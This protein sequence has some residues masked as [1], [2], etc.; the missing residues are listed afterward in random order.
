L[1]GGPL[2]CLLLAIPAWAQ[3]APAPADSLSAREALAD[4]KAADWEALAK[5]LDT[6]IARMLPCD[7]RV[8]SA[9]EEVS[10]ASQARLAAIANYLNA[11][12]VETKSEAQRARAAIAQQDAAIQALGGE[13]AEVEQWRTALDAQMGD[14]KESAKRRQALEDALAKLGEIRG[15]MDARIARLAEE[16]SRRQGARASLDT[17]ASAYD[18][19]E[20]A[21]DAEV[22]A[23]A[24][25]SARWIEYYT[26]RLARAGTECSITQQTR[27]RRKRP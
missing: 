2:V 24:G 13:R 25:E 16:A 20:R 1:K 6:K 9:I 4:K 19:R 10:R 14:L 18:V 22:T 7:T 17:L 21:V 11:A 15:M 23:L 26:A 8:R 12:A 3:P 27:P 5:G